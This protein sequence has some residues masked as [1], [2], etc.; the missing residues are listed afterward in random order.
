[1]WMTIAMMMMVALSCSRRRR[2]I[3]VA[4]S[5]HCSRSM[6]LGLC[7]DTVSVGGLSSVCLS[8]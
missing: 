7:N 4:D 2:Q 6:R 8:V 1:M 3:Y 5:W